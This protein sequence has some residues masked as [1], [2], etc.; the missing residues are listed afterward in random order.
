M[1]ALAI[2]DVHGSRE[3]HADVTSRARPCPPGIRSSRGPLSRPP[4]AVWQAPRPCGVEVG[5]ERPRRWG[6]VSAEEG[7]VPVQCFEQLIG[8]L[9]H[10]CCHW[11]ASE[12][13]S[14]SAGGR[15]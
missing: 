1:S 8:N 12:G 15:H 6:C 11:A 3:P 5:C 14:S 4:D 7:H 9:P 13:L 2:R 10:R